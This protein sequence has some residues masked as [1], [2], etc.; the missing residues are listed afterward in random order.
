MLAS[1]MSSAAASR[2]T[3]VLPAGWSMRRERSPP[4]IAA[5][6]DSIRASGARLA[7]TSGRPMPASSDDGGARGQRVGNLQT[8]DRAVEV[9]ETVGDD[10]VT[11]AGS[12]CTSTRQEPPE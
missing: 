6:V 2:P 10:Q 3:S 9:A 1:I 11:S 7:R 5:A 12:R 4:A 8:G